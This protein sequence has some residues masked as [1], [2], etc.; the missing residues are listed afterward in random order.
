MSQAL[1]KGSTSAETGSCIHVLVGLDISCSGE[2]AAC[3]GQ[4]VRDVDR[5]SLATNISTPCLRKTCSNNA[6]TMTIISWVKRVGS[7]DVGD[8]IWLTAMLLEG[9]PDERQRRHHFFKIGLQP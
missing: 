2:D 7:V 6:S 9:F 3:T 4:C 8:T 5:Y 1:S